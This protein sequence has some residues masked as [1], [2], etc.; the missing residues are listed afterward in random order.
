[1]KGQ[2]VKMYS[3]IQ[4]RITQLGIKVDDVIIYDDVCKILDVEPS[5][6]TNTRNKHMKD[7]SQFM[8]LEK[9]KRG[10]FLVVEIYDSVRERDDK[11]KLNGHF[12]KFNE[13]LGE[14]RHVQE[15][16][17]PIDLLEQFYSIIHL[18]EF[19]KE[20]H[21]MS[22]YEF[23]HSTAFALIENVDEDYLIR[24]RV[25]EVFNYG[26]LGND[27]T[28]QLLLHKVDLA[29]EPTNFIG[30]DVEVIYLVMNNLYSSMRNKLL[31]QFAKKEKIIVLVD[32]DNVTSTQVAKKCDLNVISYAENE[33]ISRFNNVHDTNYKYSDVYNKLTINQRAYVNSIRNDIIGEFIR[34][35]Y[36]D[37]TSVCINKS[38][39]SD[40]ECLCKYLGDLLEVSEKQFNEYIEQVKREVFQCFYDNEVKR[41]NGHYDEQIADH[42]EKHKRSFGRAYKQRINDKK[43]VSLKLLDLCVRQDLTSS[44]IKLI[45]QII[46]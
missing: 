33:A 9:V 1:M 10:K 21:E 7:V 34:N 37:T 27:Y 24:L 14:K 5:K 3:E 45:L 6:A 38:I 20:K 39:S 2:D 19:V 29:Q 23:I 32:K 31:C 12:E 46:E 35:Y 17:I 16:V 30:H 8:K 25:S 40:I 11:R 41:I 43:R 15:R 18:T 44:D 22:L 28:Q 4:Q 13:I 42:E 26:H 36:Y